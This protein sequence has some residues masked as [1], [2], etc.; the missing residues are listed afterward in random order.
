MADSWD[1]LVE[2]TRG[3]DVTPGKMFGC[4]GLRTGKKF[5][6]IWWHEQLVVKLP[7]GRLQELVAAGQAEV[8]EPMEGRPMN[9]WALLLG[10]V[11]WDPLVAEARDHVAAQQ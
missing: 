2:R 11:P 8:F 3:G 4:E 7:A 10:D 6:A 9:G 1:E 5:L